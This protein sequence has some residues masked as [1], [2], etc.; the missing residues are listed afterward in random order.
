MTAELRQFRLVYGLLT[1]NFFFPS[2]MYAFSP[3]RAISQFETL[4]RCL[5][6][7]PYPFSVGEAGYIWRVLGAGNVMTLAFMCF[8]LSLDLKRFYP[9]LASLAFLKA[10]SA[11]GF[12]LVFASSR[13]PAF[14]AVSLFDGLTVWAMVFF[15]R[16]AHRSLP[17]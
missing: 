8:L 2:L 5:G 15:A 11:L 3:A 9:V 4:G 7:G 17:G 6:G 12:L 16:R 1:A 14:L 13:Y 10:Y